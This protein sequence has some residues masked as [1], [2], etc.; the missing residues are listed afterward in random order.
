MCHCVDEVNLTQ[1]EVTKI[2]YMV[3]FRNSRPVAVFQKIT[4]KFLYCSNHF[5]PFG[6]IDISKDYR[7]MNLLMWTFCFICQ[8]MCK[9]AKSCKIFVC[10]LFVN[11]FPNLLSRN[12]CGWIIWWLIVSW[13]V[14]CFK[15]PRFNDCMFGEPV[16]TV[17]KHII[18]IH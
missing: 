18:C 7:Q 6:K 9:L 5:V 4:G 10:S 14:C 3:R 2:C 8:D 17:L 1:K 11:C 12:M 15:D 13:K 16:I